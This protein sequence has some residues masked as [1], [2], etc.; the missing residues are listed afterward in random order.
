[1]YVYLVHCLFLSSS[2]PTPSNPSPASK[3]NR[4]LKRGDFFRTTVSPAIMQHL[5]C[6]R[7]S[8]TL[9]E[10]MNG[11]AVGFVSEPLTN[12]RAA[13]WQGDETGPRVPLLCARPLG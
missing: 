6:S 12:G 1:M 8:D 11:R 9:A 10:G 7:A 3:Q 2:P 5:A 4:G 13:G